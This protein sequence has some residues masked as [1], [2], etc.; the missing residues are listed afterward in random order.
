MSN[1][2]QKVRDEIHR[3]L[4]LLAAQEGRSLQDITEELLEDALQRRNN[5]IDS[6]AGSPGRGAGSRE[7]NT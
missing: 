2:T 6:G 7:D 3:R 5:N 1:K 4:K